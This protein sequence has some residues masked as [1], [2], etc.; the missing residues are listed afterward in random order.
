MTPHDRALQEFNQSDGGKRF[1]RRDASFAKERERK[2]EKKQKKRG[3]R[4][5]SRRGRGTSTFV[6]VDFD[7]REIVVSAEQVGFLKLISDID[8]Q[9]A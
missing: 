9:G 8:Y 7:R 6:C 5:Q 2:R 4:T 1:K 3:R